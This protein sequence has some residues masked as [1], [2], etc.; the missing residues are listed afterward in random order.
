M[1][2]GTE[3]FTIQLSPAKQHN[4]KIGKPRKAIGQIIDEGEMSILVLSYLSLS[5][6]FFL[7]QLRYIIAKQA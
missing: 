5:I 6:N 7:I 2:E 4:I 1:F 3:I